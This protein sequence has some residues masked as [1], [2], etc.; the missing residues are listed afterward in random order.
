MHGV[1]AHELDRIEDAPHRPLA[2]TRVAVEGG[3]D[4]AA[5]GRPHHE[6][7]AGAG[8]A[9]I[10]RAARHA[11]A[12]DP[13]AANM[14]G[15]IVAPFDRGAE[16]AHGV[17]GVEDVLAFEQTGDCRLT[18]RERAEDERAVGDRFVAR[19]ADGAHKRRAAARAQGRG[20]GGVADCGFRHRLV[21]ERIANSE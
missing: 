14:P 20:G 17:G 4:R 1:R 19:H 6:P 7:A 11:K 2:Q 21:V 5:R 15:A 16:R 12:S 8:I 13:H 3:G 18:N 9:E 10:E